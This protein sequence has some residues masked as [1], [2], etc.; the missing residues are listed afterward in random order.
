MLNSTSGFSA[1]AWGA[2]RIPT[3]R[4]ET[5][6]PPSRP[7][8]LNAT[9]NR[10]GLFYSYLFMPAKRGRNS[11]SAIYLEQALRP[12]LTSPNTIRLLEEAG[13]PSVRQNP[14]HL[15]KAQEILGDAALVL[16]I[17][18]VQ[19]PLSCPSQLYRLNMGMTGYL[20]DYPQEIQVL[21]ITGVS[22]ASNALRFIQ[23]SS[24]LLWSVGIQ[25]TYLSPRDQEEYLRMLIDASQAPLRLALW[26]S[27][28]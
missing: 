9:P 8:E 1:I 17:N 24:Q 27:P 22:N 20:N 13:F 6:M 18:M 14:K 2:T 15:R 4:A 3:S 25:E 12:L 7:D 26:Y 16:S 5:L 11:R 19:R 21:G 10:T 23:L 28:S